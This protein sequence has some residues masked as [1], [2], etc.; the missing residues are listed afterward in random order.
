MVGEMSKRQTAGLRVDP[1]G[2]SRSDAPERV[3]PNPATLNAVRVQIAQAE[4]RLQVA[5]KELRSNGWPDSADELAIDLR[6]V[7]IWTQKDGW[8]DWLGRDGGEG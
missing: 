6:R 2:V 7:R 3:S 8:L 4:E 1:A 5:C